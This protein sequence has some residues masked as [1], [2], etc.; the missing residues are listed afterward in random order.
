MYNQHA[1]VEG[2]MSLEAI[3]KQTGVIPLP[4]K[5]SKKTLFRQG[6]Q[7]NRQVNTH[8]SHSTYSTLQNVQLNFHFWPQC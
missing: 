1:H 7:N 4:L 8:Y 5:T 3:L 6:H 2:L